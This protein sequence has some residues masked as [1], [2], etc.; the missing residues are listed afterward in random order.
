LETGFRDMLDMS[1]K[2]FI[3]T[4][5][6]RGCR[7]ELA[8]QRDEPRGMV[9]ETAQSWGFFHLGQFA[10][11]YRKLFGELPSQTLK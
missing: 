8:L 9:N 5:R 2:Q 1:P 11:D 4:S 10:A 7:G 6:L 3:N